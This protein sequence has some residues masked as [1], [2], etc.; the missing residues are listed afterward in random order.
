MA[1]EVREGE[2]TQGS[3]CVDEERVCAVERMDEAAVS[4]RRPASRLHRA[5]HLERE[6]VEAHFPV[7]RVEP[8]LTRQAPQGSIRAHVVEAMIVDADVREVRR[9]AFNGA[10]A[11][12]LQEVAIA[13]GVELQDGRTKLEALRPFRPAPRLPTPV[14][15]EDWR[16]VGRSPGL[17]QRSDLAGREFEEPIDLRQQIGG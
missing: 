14:H 13:G 8:M 4:D 11:C 5:A 9:H 17:L 2:R 7:R 10:R 12:E 16:P 6:L 15:G 1:E 3:D